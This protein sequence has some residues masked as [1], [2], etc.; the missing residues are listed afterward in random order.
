LG[1]NGLSGRDCAPEATRTR[2]AFS[3]LCPGFREIKTTD[4]FTA[5]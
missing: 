4:E 5:G 2:G 1:N 3:H